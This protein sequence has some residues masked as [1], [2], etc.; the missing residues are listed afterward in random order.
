MTK[1]G[2]ERALQKLTPKRREVLEHFLAGK[3][4]EDIAQSLYISK[5]TVRQHIR[6]ICQEL[7][8]KNGCNDDG[9]SQRA[10][11]IALFAQYKPEFLQQATLTEG[12]NKGSESILLSNTST[13]N[14]QDACVTTQITEVPLNKEDSG[15]SDHNFVGR[16]DDIA[17]LDKLIN[18]GAKII[19]IIAPGGT[20]KTR[21]AQKYLEIRFKTVLEFPIGKERKDI[22]LIDNLLEFNLCKLGEEPGQ[23]FMVSL[24]RLKQKL[25]TQ[26]IGISIDN[27]ETALDGSGKFIEQHRSYVELLRILTDS[28][29]KSITLITSRERLCEG[30]DITLYKLPSLNI[31]AW[32]EYWHHQEINPDTPILTEIHKAYGGNALAMKVLCN[33][34]LN[35]FNGDIIA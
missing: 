22:A 25:Q 34:I 14:K 35:D 32:Y 19:Q 16:D 33:P 10:N 27:L 23:E 11:L 9:T 5:S 30:L 6:N 8:L 15:E 3:S 31:E 20:G 13:D 12:E 7:G 18:K 24:Q 29:I 28:S 17:S 26:E 2:F 1:Q 4:D 21:L